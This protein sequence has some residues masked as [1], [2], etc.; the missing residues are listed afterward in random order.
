MGILFA[1]VRQWDIEDFF[2]SVDHKQLRGVLSQRVR[3]G[4][5]LRLIG[6]WLN[7]GVMEKGRLY[8]PETGVPQGEVISAAPLRLTPSARLNSSHLR[9][10]GL[11]R[12][13]MDFDA[14]MPFAPP[15]WT[16][17]PLDAGTVPY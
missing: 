2:G 12:A 9:P 16:L 17:K 5:M 4:V 3:D 7:A 15:R 11:Q 14:P 6:K 13:R 1:R 10:R 8:H